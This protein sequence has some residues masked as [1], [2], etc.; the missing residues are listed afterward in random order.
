MQRILEPES[1]DS[2]EEAVEYDR[3]DHQVVNEQFVTD[4][5][6]TGFAGGDVLDVGAGPAMIPIELCHRQTDCR[7]LAIDSSASMLDRARF[8][9]EAAGLSQRIQ[10]AQVDAK[11]MPFQAAQFDA[12]MSNSIMHHIPDPR[13]VAHEI[14][15]VCKP[16]GVIFV[17]DLMRPQDD[18]QLQNLVQQYT[19][20]ESPRAQQLFA[21]SLRAALNL[22][23]MRALVAELG[24]AP[25]HVRATSDRHW[26][27]SSRC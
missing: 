6:A 19:G 24:Y 11:Q 13:E 5:L 14:L 9:V 18:E 26:T 1:M 20:K 15:R 17:R 23:E 2:V 4:F 10:L 3:M 22:N 25:E 16:S 12:V 7:V 27:W 8:R 21:D